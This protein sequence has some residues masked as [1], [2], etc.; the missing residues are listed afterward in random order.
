LVR[1]AR[2]RPL[3]GGRHPHHHR[4]APRGAAPARG[5]RPRRGGH[6]PRI[7]VDDERVRGTA[8]VDREAAHVVVRGARRPR[9]RPLL[10]PRPPRRNG[11]GRPSPTSPTPAHRRSARDDP[12]QDAQLDRHAG[13]GCR[14]KFATR[15]MTRCPPGR[16]RA[17]VPVRPRRWRG[18]GG[19]PRPRDRGRGAPPRKRAGWARARRHGSARRGGR[20]R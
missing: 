20:R 15:A 4:R 7:P 17:P 10:P 2:L 11:G 9:A 18:S 14:A 5:R 6:R 16:A 3:V 1:E 13:H 19:A 12:P 8:H